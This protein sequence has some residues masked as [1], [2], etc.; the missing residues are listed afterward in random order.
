LLLQQLGVSSFF[1]K[2][3]CKLLLCW[4]VFFNLKGAS[5]FSINND[6]LKELLYDS[7]ALSHDSN[8][9][10]HDSN[11]LSH[12]SNEL[13]HDSNELSHDSNELSHAVI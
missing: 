9:L 1:F 5:L 3:E 8:A 6:H 10:S 13:S 2:N 12:D 4:C 11:A 7:N